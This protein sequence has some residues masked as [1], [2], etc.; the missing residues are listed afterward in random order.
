MFNLCL[1]KNLSSGSQM[2]ALRFV[3]IDE[4]KLFFLESLVSLDP[5]DF[6]EKMW[7][8]FFNW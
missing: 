4:S 8:E 5:F 2:Y 7:G 1:L 3:I 6:L